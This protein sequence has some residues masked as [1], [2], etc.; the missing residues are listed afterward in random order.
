MTVC[1]GS[2]ECTEKREN[3][4]HLG[5]AIFFCCQQILRILL[6]SVISAAILADDTARLTSKK[7]LFAFE[8]I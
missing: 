2:L 8:N 5:D 1:L 7:P 6:C 3:P 4:C